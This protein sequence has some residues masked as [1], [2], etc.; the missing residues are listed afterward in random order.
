MRTVVWSCCSITAFLSLLAINLAADYASRYPNSFVGRCVVQGYRTNEAVACK[1]KD[2]VR[3]IV[4]FQGA[5]AGLSSAPAQ[6]SQAQR[7]VRIYRVENLVTPPAVEPPVK[8]S[9]AA[10][11]PPE[12]LAGHIVIDTETEPVKIIAAAAEEESEVPE[13]NAGS[14]EN[15][16]PSD[17]H[18]PYADEAA[19]SAASVLEP[20]AVEWLNLVPW[21]KAAA[22]AFASQ[23]ECNSVPYPVPD[24]RE[25]PNR[26]S[27]YP[28]CPFTG[29][30]TCPHLRPTCVPATGHAPRNNDEELFPSL[31]IERTKGTPFQER[32]EQSKS[33]Y[34]DTREPVNY[35]LLERL[36]MPWNEETPPHPEVDT[37]EF[38]KSD[39]YPY[40]AGPLPY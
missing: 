20:G 23:F 16:Q 6:V 32:F 35:S 25:D 31:D 27:Q 1:C 5:A 3:A 33:K 22:V 15:S 2:E 29:E 18:M 7:P 39:A 17:L 9:K 13:L 24:C 37:T 14:D 28:G 21:F 8:Q 10:E 12:R 11:A 34:G 19:N 40:G 38:R 4:S 26:D 36:R 30:C